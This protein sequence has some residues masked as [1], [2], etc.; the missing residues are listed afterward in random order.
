MTRVLV[1]G[2]PGAGKSY[3]SKKLSEK[4]GISVTHMDNLYWSKDK[5]ACDR[6]TLVTRLMPIL[7]QNEWIIDGNYH[8]TLELRLEYCTDVFFLDFSR[9]T[10]VNGMKERIGVKRDDIPWVESEEDADELINWTSDY[11][12]KTRPIELELLAKHPELNV[13]VFYTRKEADEYL[14]S[15]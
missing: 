4:T 10:C 11:E 14:E 12:E 9:E 1:L 8:Q 3:F 13:M 6:E 5:V 15:L 2:C 7:K